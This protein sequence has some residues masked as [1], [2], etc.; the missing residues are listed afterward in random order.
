MHLKFRT[1]SL[2]VRLSYRLSAIGGACYNNYKNGDLSDK[3]NHSPIALSKV[4]ENEIPH[5][6]LG[7]IS[8]QQTTHLVLKLATLLTYV[9]IC[10][11]RI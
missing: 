10:I 8:G 11:N 6:D 5:I 1:K 3:N 4:F 9:C 2:Y 7:N